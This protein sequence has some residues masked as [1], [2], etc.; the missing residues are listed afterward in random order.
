M[1]RCKSFRILLFALLTFDK[2]LFVVRIAKRCSKK[3]ELVFDEF[4][5]HIIGRRVVVRDDQHRF[6]G[7]EDVG[8]DVQNGLRLACPWWAL[9]DA[10]RMLESSLHC[11]QLA[12]IAAERI[13]QPLFRIGLSFEKTGVEV[14][15]Q[16]CFV[17]H[18]P[19]FVVLFGK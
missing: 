15:C 4:F 7:N 17:R 16:Y 9:D 10:D 8:D 2:A 13:D 6:S 3:T 18:E 11:F 12:R 14:G 19:H 1:P 5:Q